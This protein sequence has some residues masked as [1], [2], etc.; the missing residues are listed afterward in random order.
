MHDLL[1]PNHGRAYKHTGM[2]Y[3]VLL[4]YIS[5]ACCSNNKTFSH[6]IALRFTLECREL[7]H[8]DAESSTANT[9]C[10]IQYSLQAPS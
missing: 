8:A 9:V 2:H 5:L 1:P 6:M 3:C 4:T 10:T 7:W